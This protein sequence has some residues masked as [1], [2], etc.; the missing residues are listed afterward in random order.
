M[1]PL[2]EY[3]DRWYAQ[4]ESSQA[5][6]EHWM[7][8]IKNGVVISNWKILL[9]AVPCYTDGETIYSGDVEKNCWFVYWGSA[10]KG[11]DGPKEFFEAQPVIYPYVAYKRRGKDKIVKTEDLGRRI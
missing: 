1:N 2:L 3:A 8:C 7:E 4:N 10:A 9:L 11:I 6:S 5:F